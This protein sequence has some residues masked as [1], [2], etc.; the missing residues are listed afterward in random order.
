MAEQEEMRYF[1]T[2]GGA[3]TLTFEEV[4]LTTY[5]EVLANP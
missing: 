2:R 5:P 1:S 3:E 4:R